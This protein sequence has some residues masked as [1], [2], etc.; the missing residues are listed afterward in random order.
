M[1]MEVAICLINRLHVAMFLF[2]NKSQMM[3]KCDEKK[4]IAYEAQPSVALMSLPLFD[5]LCC[6]LLL[7]RPSTTRN[8]FVLFFFIMTERRNVGKDDVIYAS[9]L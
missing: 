3:S 6:D 5:V 1:A 2:S 9:V 7:N 8:L 4:R